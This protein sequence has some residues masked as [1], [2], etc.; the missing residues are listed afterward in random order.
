MRKNLMNLMVVATCCLMV[1]GWVWAEDE[2]DYKGY[3][4]LDN[5]M[6]LPGKK[7]PAGVSTTR[8]LRSDATARVTAAIG[9]DDVLGVVDMALVFTGF[10]RQTTSMT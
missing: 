8:F 6:S 9:Q 2:I 1:P 4:E 10:P 5:R 7:E 3:I